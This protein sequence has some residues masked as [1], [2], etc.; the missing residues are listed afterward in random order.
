MERDILQNVWSEW[1]VTKEI[2][3][4]SFGT[5]YEAVRTDHGVQSKA[6][7]KV[8]TIPTDRSE[9]DS[10]RSEGMTVDGTRTYFQ[11]IVNDFVSEV[12]LMETFK[13]MQNIVSVEDYRVMEKKDSVGW[14]IFIRMELLTPFNTYIQNRQMTEK[15]VIRLG[16][17]IC[18]ALEI[19]A[20]RKIIHRDIKPENIFINDFGYF[21]LGD[22]G[23]ARKLE[24]V[25]GGLSQKGTYNY[26]APEIAAGRYYD[27]TVDIYSLGIVLYRLL[28]DNRLPFITEEQMFNPNERQRAVDRRLRGEP[29]PVPKNASPAM[30]DVILRACA[31]DPNIRFKSAT[32]FKKALTDVANGTYAPKRSASTDPNATAVVNRPIASN[33]EYDSQTERVDTANSS[34]AF[35]NKKKKSKAP[36]IALVAVLAVVLIAGIGVVAKVIVN[37][38][39]FTEVLSEVDGEESSTEDGVK[40]SSYDEGL[41]ADAIS[42]ADA[43]A[44]DGDYEAA[45]EKV[46]LML[47]TYPD[48]TSLTD[49]LAEYTEGYETV[50]AEQT[51]Q[52]ILAQAADYADAGDYATAIVIISDALESSGED[53][54]YQST[55]DEYVEAY[56]AETITEADA[57]ALADEPDY[58][59]AIQVIETAIA[60]IGEDDELSEKASGYED[61]YVEDAIGEIDAKIATKD[62][63]TAEELL[64]TA[65]KAFPSNE[66]L[67]AEKTTL[68]DA[69]YKYEN[70]YAYVGRDISPYTSSYYKEYTG[71]SAFYMGGVAYQYGF[72]AVPA[73]TTAMFNLNGEYDYVSGLAGSIDGYTKS[74]TFNFIGDGK[75]L[76]TVEITGGQLPKEFVI[77]VSGISQ[78][79]I[80]RVDGSSTSYSVGFANV[81]FY[82]SDVEQVDYALVRSSQ[83]EVYVGKD[84]SPYTSSYYKEY[85]GSSSFYMG[86]VAYQY[87][88]TAVPAYTTAMFNLNGEYDYISGLA[89]SVDGYMKS[90]TFNFVGDGRVLG[91]VEITGGELPKEFTIDVSGVNQLTI[92]RVDGTNTSYSVGFANVVFY[93][94]NVEKPDYTVITNL[95]DEAYIGRDISPY[96][97]SY[98]KEYSG[99]SS[100]YMEG[101]T[102]QYGFTAVPSY[103]V[104]LFNLNGEYDYVSGLAGCIDGYSKSATFNFIGDG[105]LL[106]TVEIVG[107]TSTSE[108]KI[109]VSGIK[110]LTIQRVDGSNTSYSVGFANVVFT[111]GDT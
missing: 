42:E 86:G 83:D 100:F 20:Q 54:D 62:F 52:E 22:F 87:G 104:A 1:T 71:S 82:T 88:F 107:G 53:A 23:I 67:K 4:G 95:Q 68:S 76:G 111:K 41:I 60:V 29:L 32:E 11:N 43:L 8:I 13:G 85:D 109:N 98:Y 69:V 105:K 17:D 75:V 96:T 5:V 64:N 50:L 34:V 9:V 56:K 15:E 65:L 90:A 77:D 74:A 103:T 18:T 39:D 33:S 79:T 35:G 6:A 31:Y 2:G 28:N 10:L 58:L 24:N 81:V 93:T 63:D 61:S 16:I 27:A 66:A 101:T 106:G 97:S 44:E 92:Q 36:L 47:V 110:Q 57:L 91:T 3:R 80:Q 94:S 102:Y 59:G 12:Q 26:M 46:Q 19:C 78:L 25:T 51:K 7:V 89:G 45:I 30:T 49:K 40:Y 38:I 84:I 72:I 14:D 48:S 99:S 21:K 108:F 70:S 55:L 73:Y 37:N